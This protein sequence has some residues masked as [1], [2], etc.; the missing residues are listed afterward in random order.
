MNH[1]PTVVQIVDRILALDCGESCDVTLDPHITRVG[2]LEWLL[3]ICVRQF[4]TEIAIR[5]SPE[6]DHV[7]LTITAT[8]TRRPKASP[9][10]SQDGPIAAPSEEP[11]GVV[12]EH[13][14]IVA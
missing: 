3:P 5:E 11:L 9:P 12:D 6:G 7:L 13:L 8:A 10:S 2:N 4:G 1:E 14:A